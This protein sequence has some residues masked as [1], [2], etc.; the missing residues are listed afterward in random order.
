MSSPN[1]I[2]CVAAHFTAKAGHEETVRQLL[3][4]AVAAVRTHEPGNLVYT[5]HQDPKEPTQFFIY[6]Q[7]A[8]Q[9]ALEAHR[10]S[11]H[12][13]ELVARQIGPLLAERDVKFY[14]LLS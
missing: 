6:E 5:A 10:D 13:Q 9:T 7:Y 4:Q 11:A 3:Q 1:P 2:I 12:Y 14:Q 8:D